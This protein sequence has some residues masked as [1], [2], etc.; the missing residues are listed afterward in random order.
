MPETY[1]LN[2]MQRLLLRAA[3]D[4]PTGAGDLGRAA[5]YTPMKN[6]RAACS[7]SMK[8]MAALGLVEGK[9]MNPA[10][11]NSVMLWTRTPAGDAE[12]AAWDAKQPS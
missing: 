5:G 6:Y 2:P 8:I 3:N 12:V 10:L 7:E 1:D 4:K 11:N 9:A